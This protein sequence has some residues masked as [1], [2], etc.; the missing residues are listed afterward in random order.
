M[1]DGGATVWGVAAVAGKPGVHPVLVVEVVLFRILLLL[2]EPAH[3]IAAD[4]P[5]A[6]C[7]EGE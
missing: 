2:L 1:Q 3:D 4:V 5:Q 7:C 6:T